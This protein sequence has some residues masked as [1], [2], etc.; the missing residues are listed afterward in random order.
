ML[1]LGAPYFIVS[2]C[3]KTR[4]MWTPGYGW[5]HENIVL[6]VHHDPITFM[7]M[8]KAWRRDCW[9]LIDVLTII[10]LWWVIYRSGAKTEKRLYLDLVS[11]FILLLFAKCSK[12]RQAFYLI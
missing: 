11:V 6:S 12:V 5:I 4:E 7:G 9:N 1:I 10:V 2:G 3:K 8:P